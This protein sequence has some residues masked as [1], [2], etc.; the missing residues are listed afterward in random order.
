MQENSPFATCTQF[1]DYHDALS[2]EKSLR[3]LTRRNNPTA[4]GTSPLADSTS[5]APNTTPETSSRHSNT[6]QLTQ[7]RSHMWS[8]LLALPPRRARSPGLRCRPQLHASSRGR[9]RYPI[10]ALPATTNLALLRGSEPE[11]SDPCWR[12]RNRSPTTLPRVSSVRRWGLNRSRRH[13]PRTVHG[14]C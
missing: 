9:N 1:V 4:L 6:L 12:P 13:P 14:T 7:T 8:P 10:V 11:H 3:G 5:L 2:P